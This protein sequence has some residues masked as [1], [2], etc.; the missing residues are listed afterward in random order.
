MPRNYQVFNGLMEK[1]KSS[2]V[3]RSDN[4]F[5]NISMNPYVHPLASIIP[6]EIS[7]FGSP[8]TL[9]SISFYCKNATI[10]SKEILTKNYRPRPG[11]TYT[12]GSYQVYGDTPEFS[13]KFYMGPYMEERKFFEQWMAMV[14]DPKTNTANYYD[15]YARGNSVTIYLLPKDLAGS[16]VN[17][18]TIHEGQ[19]L[20]YVEY[21]ECYPKL[22]SQ[23]EISYGESNYLELDVKM[24][25]RYYRTRFD[26]DTT[27]VDP[28]A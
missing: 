12:I 22:I 7:N 5:V 25:Y 27:S 26:E 23:N 6:Q 13:L 14:I 9:R 24:S 2:G 21:R 4:F 17:K 16:V 11:N 18:Q 15:E 20:Y 8:E 10:P 19:K 1:L 28:E 3:A